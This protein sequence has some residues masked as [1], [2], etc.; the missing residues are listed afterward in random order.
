METRR[1]VPSAVF[2]GHGSNEQLWWDL[3]AQES[4][5]LHKEI[6]RI[7]AEDY[8]RRIDELTDLLEVRRL[9]AQPGASCRWVSE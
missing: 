9:M 3:P 2:P 7:P 1:R 4:F 6:Y 8:T 5:R